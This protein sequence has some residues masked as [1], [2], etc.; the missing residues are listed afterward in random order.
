MIHTVVGL[1][2]YNYT[3]VKMDI[4]EGSYF[5]I[6][7]EPDNAYSKNAVVVHFKDRKIG[8][9]SKQSSASV[10][11][12]LQL[13]LIKKTVKV[14]SVHDTFIGVETETQYDETILTN[15]KEE[16][17]MN[18]S[19]MINNNKN[20][21]TSAAYFEA[22]RIA[23]NQISKIV[24]TKAP[25]MVKGYV[26]TPLG[27]LVVANIFALAVEQFRPNDVQ[28][29]KLRNAMITSAYQEL[30]QTINIEGMFTE[31]MENASI[32]NAL[33]K[34]SESEVEQTA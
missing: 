2:Y 7:R 27:K 24:A 8:Y 14:I 21:A 16:P 31:L 22:G 29:G 13:G 4:V 1:P 28:L 26:D 12:D 10:S 6:E 18:L 15:T 9:I 30:I 5:T 11:K 3:K 34:V 20:L 33:T 17:K 19:T 25:L 32:K 23:N